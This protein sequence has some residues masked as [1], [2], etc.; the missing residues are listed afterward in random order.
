MMCGFFGTL[1]GLERAVAIGARWAYG[2][3]F[4]SALGAALLVAGAG[5]MLPAV[6][7]SLGAGVLVAASLVAQQRQPALHSL[8]LTLGAACWLAGNLAWVAGTP[9]VQ[10]AAWWIAFLVVTVAGER[11]EL[12]RVMPPSRGMKRGFA[13]LIG[14]TL[15]GAAA[16]ALGQPGG[17]PLLGASFALLGGWLMVQDVARRTVRSPGLTRYIALCLL[18]GYVWLVAG[19]VTY[20]AAGHTPGTPGFDAALH[21]L[22]LGFVFAMV[23]GHAP[24]ILPAVL[25]VRIGFHLGFYVPLVLLHASL[26]LRI[27]GDVLGDFPLRAWGGLGN[28]AAIGL[29]LLTVLSTI[30]VTRFAA[31]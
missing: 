18:G 20:M 8:V 10:T 29:F 19:G 25:R 31:R 23:F 16:G 21:M 24:I 5:S 26:G 4:A 28:A 2:G 1:I 6:L 12:S 13:L 9:L 7:F 27:A 30:L 17:P 14:T 22:L 11:L 3:P 15:A